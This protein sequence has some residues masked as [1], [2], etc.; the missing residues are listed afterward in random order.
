LA[1]IEE[2]MRK[3]L[4]QFAEYQEEILKENDHKEG[5]DDCFLHNLY[6]MLREEMEELE[7]VLNSWGCLYK[8]NPTKNLTNEERKEFKE[9]ISKECADVANFAMMIYD[10]LGD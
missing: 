1:G 4:K 7:A 9:Q 6:Y 2:E 3:S 8:L 5:W 10:N